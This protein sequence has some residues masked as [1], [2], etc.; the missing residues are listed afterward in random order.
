LDEWELRQFLSSRVKATAGLLS[1]TFV[2]AESGTDNLI[3]LYQ[4]N[5][6]EIFHTERLEIIQTIKPES[7][8]LGFS[9]SA[10]NNFLLGF[11]ENPTQIYLHDLNQ[12][13]KSKTIDFSGKLP[14]IEHL[15]AMAANGIGAVVS[16]KQVILVDLLKETILA[17]A[18]IRDENL[19]ECNISPSGNMVVIKTYA[20]WE[21][22]R[23]NG[24]TLEEL[25]GL[26]ADWQTVSFAGFLSGETDKLVLVKGR[27]VEV[28]NC[29][30]L[31]TEHRWS[32]EGTGEPLP[33]HLDPD[34][35]KLLLRQ[36]ENLVLLNTSTGE[37]EMIGKSR[38]SYNAWHWNFVFNN[39]QVFWSQGKRL[40][41]TTQK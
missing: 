3:F 5:H 23:Y 31:E 21:F 40:P 36:D 26:F 11:L 16:E 6:V 13:E 28:I 37:N 18:P 1:P 17:R 4:Y 38:D 25:A 7:R 41:V 33:F 27:I 22:F 32:V 14:W 12:P 2:K 20:G 35:R 30:T 15:A 8:I 39:N 10:G 19:F 34:S 24:E 29:N 9:L